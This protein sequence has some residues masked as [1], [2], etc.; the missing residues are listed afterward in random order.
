MA[1]LALDLTPEDSFVVL[2]RRILESIVERRI[3]KA[4][5]LRPFLH[6]IAR[7][8]AHLDSSRLRDAIRD[9]EREFFLA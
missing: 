5:D 7:E 1:P 2:R 3:F 8:N 4:A 9:V 6:Q